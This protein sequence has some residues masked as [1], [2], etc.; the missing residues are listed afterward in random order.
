MGNRLETLG[1]S[2]VLVFLI[3]LL[4]LP[5]PPAGAQG[6][7]FAA[8]LSGK[9]QAPPID[10][11]AKATF[12]L[13]GSGK[14]LLFVTAAEKFGNRDIVFAN[15]GIATAALAGK[16]SLATFEQVLRTNLTGVSFTIQAAAPE[17]AQQVPRRQS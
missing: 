17:T 7:K 14:S 12:V 3:G 11:P 16:T 5:I 2:C 15:A 1:L 4:L 6:A 13:S 8:T 10:T 9:E